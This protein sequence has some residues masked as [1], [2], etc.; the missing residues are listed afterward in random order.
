MVGCISWCPRR[1]NTKSKSAKE[2]S[3]HSDQ[4]NQVIPT[5]ELYVLRGGQK[6]ASVVEG[7]S[8]VIPVPFLAEFLK[9][10]VVV[11]K[12]C[13]DAIAIEENVK[14]L[15][16]RVYSLSLAIIDTVPVG[17]GASE[18]LKGRIKSLQSMLDGI[19]ADLEEIKKQGRII[20]VTFRD[21]NK[22]RVDKCVSRVNE[23]LERFGI[24]HQLRVEE[25][26]EKIMSNYRGMTTQLDR[27]EKTVKDIKQL[28]NAPDVLH[29]QDM[30]PKHRIFHG[31]DDFVHEVASL[32]TSEHTSRV[33]IT[34]AGGRGKT[35]V[36]LAFWVP[37]IEATTADLL[38]RTLYTQLRVTAESYDSLDSL[39]NELDASKE[40]RVLLLDNFETP[41][42]SRD[43]DKVGDLLLQLAKLPHVALL[44]TMTSAF[45]PSK[46]VE[47]QHK[48]LLSLDVA[49]ARDTFKDRYPSAADKPKLDELLESVGFEPLAITLLAASGDTSQASPEDLLEE[50]G[51]AGTGI[52]TDMDRTISMSV[53]RENMRLNPEA[54]TLLAILSMLP[55]GTTGN[56]LRWWAPTLTSHSAAIST[57]RTAALVQQGDGGLKTSR[58]FVLPTIQSY[59]HQQNRI[60][61]DVQN[62]VLG[63]CYKFVLD[64]KSIPDDD[65]YKDD[66]AALVGEETNIQG[67]LM[68]TDAQGLRPNALDVLIAFSLYQ[69]RTKPSTEVARHALNLAMASQDDRHVA[70]AH[71]CLGK[72]YLKL[73]RYDDASEH[74]EKARSCFKSLPDGPDL[75]RAGECSMELSDTWIYWGNKSSH[76]IH[77]LVLE[78]NADLSHDGS[79]YHVARGL[80]GL[81][82]F[83]RWSSYYRNRAVETL[84]IAKTTFEKLKCPAST[85]Q[86]LFEMART[87]ALGETYPKALDHARQA[88]VTAEQVGDGALIGQAL[89][90]LARY[91]MVMA[92]NDEALGIIERSLSNSQALG[93]PLAIAQNLELLSYNCAARMNLLAARAAYKG[94]QAQYANLGSTKMGQDGA[95]RCSDNLRKL[96]GMKDIDETGLSMLEKPM[97]E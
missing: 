31:R 94:A 45:P 64:H 35:S 40:R 43:R 7:L 10:V 67:L 51:K 28:H 11:L 65:K 96:D 86:C 71:H 79:E 83:Y 36:A 74:L 54:G 59:M 13:E 29:R 73:D 34:G 85:S 25:L 97:L 76:Q 95:A 3:S 33:C 53:N 69:L 68:Q 84:S 2:E 92:F 52:I 1:A 91:L 14:D 88:L 17:G 47:W 72:I 18:E 44:V 6:L 78:A 30:P 89:I 8:G 9:G 49:A 90:I 5:T 42:F 70:E 37:C 80:L 27:I 16:K 75:L 20:L 62:E 56:S 61:D 66:L 12:A 15:Q 32:L 22:D 26:L 77:P 46:D 24:S 4:D 23:A 58:I 93:R 21:I 19:V 81:G 38:R 60:P 57:L 63:V 55:A 87:Y 50:W 48:D 39:I 82:H 41:W